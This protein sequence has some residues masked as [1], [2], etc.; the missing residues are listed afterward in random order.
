[1][2]KSRTVPFRVLAAAMFANHEAISRRNDGIDLY[3]HMTLSPI[4]RRL[5]IPSSRLREYLEWLQER[6]YI[7]DLSL[8]FNQADFLIRLPDDWNW[9]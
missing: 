9:G 5:S 1:M 8:R 6:G 3:V 2:I 4:Q 7:R